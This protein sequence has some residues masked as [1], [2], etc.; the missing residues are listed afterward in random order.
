MKNEL[1]LS[2]LCRIAQW[3]GEA[4]MPYFRQP[5]D[6]ARK[7]DASPVTA[8]D[9]AAHRV[10]MDELCAL[11]PDIPI[12]SEESK[13]H[14]LPEGT[15]TFWLVDPLD[16]TKSFIS[17]TGE[18]TVNIGLIEEG[19]PTIGVIYIPVEKVMYSAAVGLGAWC[20]REGEDKQEITT[21][22]VPEEGM[23]AVVSLS[24]LDPKTEAFL[25]PMTIA[26]TVSAGSSL[27]FCRVADGGAD[28]YP[29]FGPTM[30][31][32]TAAGHAIAVAAGGRVETP[33]GAPFTYG[34]DALRNGPFIVWGR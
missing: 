14:E 33:D 29:R 8:A 19:T 4:I 2:K 16:G 24:H 32:D 20:E 5:I 7:A 34:K 11:T 31:W 12:V 25:E 13:S 21:R 6:V 28:V 1:F 22:D 9:L 17:G 23:S 18:F 15:S 27:K 3:G 26:H 10:I 30:E